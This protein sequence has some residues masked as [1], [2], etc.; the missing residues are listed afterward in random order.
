MFGQ[1]ECNLLYS[2]LNNILF[3]NVVNNIILPPVNSNPIKMAFLYDQPV[4]NL[5]LLVLFRIK[6]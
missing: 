2:V 6:G 4:Q 1:R 3:Y 5:I